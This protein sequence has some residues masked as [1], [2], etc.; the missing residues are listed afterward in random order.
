MA[1]RRNLPKKREPRPPT[2]QL[3]STGRP[4]IAPSP[5]DF[6]V[7]LGMIDAARTRA[8]AA[9]N[10]E[11]IDLYWRIGEHIRRRIT[12][13]GWGERTVEA[14]AEFIRKRQPNVRGFSASNLWRMMQFFETYH[15][16][17]KLAALLRE[18]SWR[19][20]RL[21]TEKIAR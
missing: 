10:T 13:D 14:L 19:G 20:S 16:R 8:V 17:P 6:D 2:G 4:T 7:V 15:D 5:T 11:L 9:V 18:L 1:K 3:R 12:A 21:G